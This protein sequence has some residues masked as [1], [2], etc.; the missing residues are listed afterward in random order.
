MGIFKLEPK[1]NAWHNQIFPKYIEWWYL[2]AMTYSN[3]IFSGSFALWGNLHRP[4]SCV[5]RSDFVFTFSDG[6]V[7]DFGKKINLADFHASTDGC[8]VQ[9]EY[10][11]F[12]N[13]GN[14][15]LLHLEQGREA[16]L[17]IS[18]TPECSGFGYYHEFDS[19]KGEYFYWIV[20]VPKGVI[21]GQIQYMG[22]IYTFKGVGYHD[23]NWASINLSE[24]FNAW[25]WGR[26]LAVDMGIIFTSVESD[27]ETLFQGMAIIERGLTAN[28]YL[29][30]KFDQKKPI[31]RIENT[32]V[33]W[34]LLITEPGL[35]FEM[36]IVKKILV[37]ERGKARDYQRFKSNSR[38]RL[39]IGGAEYKLNGSLIHEF[40]ILSPKEWGKP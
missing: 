3:D 9:M 24:K 27:Q 1:D 4:E 20:P 30:L 11:S 18:L 32:P 8:Y 26:Y 36:D 28:E 7:V 6:R 23:H 25:I 34:S 14:L 13:L 33:G 39:S 38:G 19:G 37:F 31:L 10:D 16:I 2:D 29:Y 40:K 21:T 5:V 12:Q 17:D 15:F 22:Q 35:R